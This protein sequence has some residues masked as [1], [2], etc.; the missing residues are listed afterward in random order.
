[1]SLS[2]GFDSLVDLSKK[3]NSKQ[4][5]EYNLLSI[6]IE[7][8]EYIPVE[9]LFPKSKQYS[10]WQNSYK[11]NI[12]PLHISDLEDSNIYIENIPQIPRM[13]FIG[14]KQFWKNEE[15]P[16]EENQLCMFN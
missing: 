9:I 12:L 5:T 10:F 6:L 16:D 1:M 13:L 11:K 2:F 4:N 7:D 15:L 14:K 8:S 3:S